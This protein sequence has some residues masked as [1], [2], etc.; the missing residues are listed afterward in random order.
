[1]KNKKRRRVEDRAPDWARSRLD[2]HLFQSARVLN[3]TKARCGGQILKAARLAADTFATGNKMLICGNG[4]SAADAQH[5]AAE[6]VSRL[7]K[8]FERP[9]LPAIALTTDTSILTAYANDCGFDGVFERQVEALGKPGDLL[10]CVSTSGNSRNVILA[11]HAADRV[12]MQTI[13][14]CGDGGILAELATIAIC[15]PSRSTQYIQEAHLAVEHI[16]CDL[17]E[18]YLF[19]EQAMNEIR[20]RRDHVAE[21]RA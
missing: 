3:E 4:G 16:L 13:A 17:T 12:G 8:G 11:L 5:I 2:E 20:Q 15:I 21:Y 7:T 14:L 9:A 1:M 6:Y 18:R 19:T 10:V